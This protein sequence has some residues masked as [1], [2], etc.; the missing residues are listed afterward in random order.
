M[1]SITENTI[2]SYTS[3]YV[4]NTNALLQAVKDDNS[5]SNSSTQNTTTVGDTIEVSTNKN[6]AFFKALNEVSSERGNF[7]VDGSN[8]SDGG[9]F[10][11][12]VEMMKDH[13]YNV[14][15]FDSSC[16]SYSDFIDKMKDFL[17]SNSDSFSS[18]VINFCDDLQE[19]LKAY[20]IN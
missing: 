7:Q 8:I 15:S 17:S 4:N 11:T 2:N 9:A 13:G 1:N 18:N 20:G 16:S 12:A 6:T 5:N 3:N 10:L 14:P 19:R